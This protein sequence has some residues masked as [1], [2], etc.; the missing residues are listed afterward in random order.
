MSNQDII[1]YQ[2]QLKTQNLNKIAL[3]EQTIASATENISQLNQNINQSN[4]QIS[5][6]NAQIIELQNGNQL[7]DEAIAIIEQS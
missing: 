1:N 7:I 3:L 4:E 6:C 5:D 2:N